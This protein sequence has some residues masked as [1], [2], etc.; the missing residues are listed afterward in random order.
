[1]TADFEP[2]YEVIGRIVDVLRHDGP[3]YEL[4]FRDKAAIVTEDKRVYSAYVEL[5]D[6]PPL[7][8][9]LPR[10]LVEAAQIAKEYEQDDPN[11][12]LGDVPVWIHTFAPVYDNQLAEAIDR[13]VG[14]L[15]TSTPL[16]TPSIIASGLVQVGQRR[17]VRET[18]FPAWRITRQFRAPLVGVV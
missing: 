7:R 2:D 18:S 1:M 14:Y 16:S 8:N 10:V 5:P 11:Q 15:L 6:N 13:R 4:L 17:R 9:L 12:P 3:L